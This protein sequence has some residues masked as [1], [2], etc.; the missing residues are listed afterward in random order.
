MRQAVELAKDLGSRIGDGR[1]LQLQM[2]EAL[3]PREV[4]EAHVADLGA[5]E[6]KDVQAGHLRQRREPR[7]GHVRAFEVD[8]RELRETGQVLQAGIADLRAGQV[9][10]PDLLE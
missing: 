5:V 10:P 4:S 2:K 8:A 9:D 3:H 1:S 7:V 6:A